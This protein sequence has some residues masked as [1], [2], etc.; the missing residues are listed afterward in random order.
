MNVILVV[1]VVD[2]IAITQLDHMS[3]AVI[4][5]LGLE[6]IDKH[7]F[8]SQCMYNNNILSSSVHADVKYCNIVCV[9]QDFV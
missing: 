2:S 4:L 3:A 8:V 6:M 1:T 5:A 9:C 7:A